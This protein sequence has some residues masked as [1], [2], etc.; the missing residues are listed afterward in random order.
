MNKSLQ[1]IVLIIFACIFSCCTKTIATEI[2][3]EQDT[4]GQ[5]GAPAGKV[6]P[7]G[8]PSG[9]M[10]SKVIGVNGGTFT[11]ADKRLSI[12]FPQGALTGNTTI[13]VQPITNNTPGG[14]GTAYRITPHGVNFAKPVEISFRY[15][16]DDLSTTIPAAMA[17]AYQDT[18]GI[19]QTI[20]GGSNDTTAKKVTISSTHFSDWSVFRSYEMVPGVSF[21]GAGSTLGLKLIKR[22]K[23]DG[24][25]IPMPAG[26][27]YDTMEA[28]VKEWQL[29]G[30]GLLSPNKNTAVYKAPLT[31]PAKL[32][33]TVSATLNTPTGIYRY[34]ANIFIVAIISDNTGGNGDGGNGG[35]SGVNFRI[36]K[37]AWM[38]AL[39][40]GGLKVMHTPMGDERYFTAFIPGSANSDALTFHWM[41]P[42]TANT[43]LRWTTTFPDFLY[44][45]NQGG[46][47]VYYFQYSLPGSVASGGG[48]KWFES[49]ELPGMYTS[50]SFTIA[51]SGK[52][53]VPRAGVPPPPSNHQIEGFFRIAW[54][55]N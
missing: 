18:S 12:K 38:H 36:D 9:A 44:S 4:S 20:G 22:V 5:T 51:T 35:F 16:Y 31:A 30:P 37:G 39:C 1:I 45:Y 32:P 21:I 7:A 48:I 3:S 46:N 34:T 54:G 50:G 10:E 55:G 25:I 23:T 43:T 27:V 40:Y 28:A 49:T 26:P 47:A 19:W 11:T 29:T 52:L 42:A 24:P 15:A 8:T 41:G 13:S 17:I 2:G 14:L 53:T 33:V 6:T